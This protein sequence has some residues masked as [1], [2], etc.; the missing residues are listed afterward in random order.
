MSNIK[1]HI[2]DWFKIIV[3]VEFCGGPLTVMLKIFR[4]WLWFFRDIRIESSNILL[5]CVMASR[6]P[7]VNQKNFK[8]RREMSLTVFYVAV[9]LCD[10]HS[11]EWPY[12]PNFLC[13]KTLKLSILYALQGPYKWGLKP[14]ASTYKKFLPMNFVS[15]CV[16]SIGNTLN[17]LVKLPK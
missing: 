2:P 10:T 5:S 1:H 9:G 17:N 13:T 16:G 4:I 14:W 3:T 15:K 12:L 8:N 11:F 6:S 7:H